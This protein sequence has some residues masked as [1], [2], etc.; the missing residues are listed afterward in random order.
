VSS[1]VGS[2]RGLIRQGDVLLVP[3]DAVPER[4]LR[5]PE[6]SRSHVLAEGEATGHAHR[7]RSK[8]PAALRRGWGRDRREF[9]TVPDGADALLVHEEH[10]PIE[11]A[12]GVWEL[13]RQREYEPS[14]IRSWRAV[15]D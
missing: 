7:L 13:R 9:V 4:G 14:R 12:A 3:V 8:R 10:D 5:E 1:E 11:V 15:R 6:F 2:R